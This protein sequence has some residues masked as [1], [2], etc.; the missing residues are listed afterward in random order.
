M[1]AD[2]T[3]RW[4]PLLAV[5]GGALALAACAQTTY[6]TGKGTGVQTILDFAKAGSLTGPEEQANIDF[7]PR[8][9][10]VAPPS[11]AALPAPGSGS[12]ATVAANWPND[13]DQQAAAVRAEIAAAHAEGRPVRVVG[14]GVVEEPAPVFDTDSRENYRATPEQI[15]E[16]RRRVALFN[17]S[18]VDENGNPI[19]VFLSDPP[20]GYLKPD[21][22][23]PPPTA[24]A[25]ES[26]RRLIKWPWQWFRPS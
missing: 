19:R 7:T 15:A 26:R 24:P 11:G 16:Y 8:P 1:N 17:A 5:A 22:S 12:S 18:T 2:F 6:G 14:T 4:L 21:A 20:P 23:A 3:G 13:P 10:I 25:E 9:P